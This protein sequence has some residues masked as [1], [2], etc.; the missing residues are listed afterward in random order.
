MDEKV[1][2]TVPEVK[3]E[4][5]TSRQCYTSYKQVCHPVIKKVCE[6]GVYQ[7]IYHDVTTEECTQVPR[8]NCQ[9]IVDRYDYVSKQV[10][11]DVLEVVER[12]VEHQVCADVPEVSCHPVPWDTPRQNCVDASVDVC[13]DVPKEE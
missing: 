11:R 8:E 10:C 7:E 1:C 9:D 2:K 6:M 12:I 4:D 3:C 5:V 13:E